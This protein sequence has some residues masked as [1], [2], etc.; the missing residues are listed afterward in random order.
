MRRI[1]Y[2]QTPASII[3]KIAKKE[4]VHPLRSLTDLRTRLGPD[5]RC[6]AFFHPSFKDEPL[7]FVH[8]ALCSDG[9]PESMDDLDSA[10]SNTALAKPT[11]ATFYSITSTQPGLKGVDL[12]NVLIKRVVQSLQAEYPTLQTFSTLSPIPRFR[13]WLQQKVNIPSDSTFAHDLFSRKETEQLQKIL[14]SHSLTDVP[15]DLFSL[16]EDNTWYESQEIA[17]ALKP[18]LLRLAA[19]YLTVETHRGKIL[20]NVARFHIKN[21]AEMYRLN[22]LADI[23]RKGM[24]NSSGIMINYL[25]NLDTIE[26]NQTNY[27]LKKI[28]PICDGVAKWKD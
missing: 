12:G 8:V 5:R 7:V 2:D 18:I 9:I 25:Y 6:F 28:I 21:G 15:K 11:V 3:E 27:E 19:Y 20:D 23:S 10:A 24:H 26:K 14:K 13:K 22:Y 4:A 16:L 17:L 1:T